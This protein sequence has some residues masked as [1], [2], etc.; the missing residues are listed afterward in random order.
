MSVNFALDVLGAGTLPGAPTVADIMPYFL[1][2]PP[3]N[4]E[5]LAALWSHYLGAY[6]QTTAWVSSH[7]VAQPVTSRTAA[8]MMRA[9]RNAASEWWSRGDRLSRLGALQFLVGSLGYYNA[10]FRNPD[11]SMNWDRVKAASDA[12]IA[13]V[14]GDAAVKAGVVAA[15]VAAGIANTAKKIVETPF[16]IAKILAYGAVAIGVVGVGVFA[17]RWKHSK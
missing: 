10:H 3:A 15:D 1:T 7:S 6:D 14:T 8:A 9:L 5:E 11:G 13:Q 17:W 2:A 16:D 12:G 4:D